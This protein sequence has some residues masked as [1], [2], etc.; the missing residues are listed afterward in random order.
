MMEEL[1]L[2]TENEGGDHCMKVEDWDRLD[3]FS[4]DEKT[5]GYEPA[6]GD[7]S[8]MKLY[9][10]LQLDA[11]RKYVGRPFRIHCGYEV[12]GHA[13]MSYHSR[14]G[15]CRAVDFDCAEVEL[16]ELFLIATKFDFSAIGRY[17]YWNHKGLHVDVR[18]LSRFKRR[19]Y[20]IRDRHGYVYI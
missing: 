17:P 19:I 15:I 2:V 13:P 3:H 14:D 8:K 12:E 20:W 18:P 9:L 1:S 7:P 5:R 11:M 16:D 10:M 6:W 4:I